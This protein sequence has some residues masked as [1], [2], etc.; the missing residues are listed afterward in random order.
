MPD[1]SALLPP[2]ATAFQGAATAP[3]EE[4]IEGRVDPDTYR[5]GPG[6]QFALR[7]SDLMDPRILRVSPAG[8]LLLPDAGSVP[9]A[10]LTLREVQAKVR[11]ALRPFIRGKGFALILDRPRRFRMPVLGE[12]ERRGVVT[13]QA[14]VRASEAIAAAGG[15]TYLGARRGIE[16]RRGTDTLRVDLVRYLNSGDLSANPLVFETDVLYVPA[17]GAKVGIAGAL[18]H[19]GDYDYMVGDRL[20]VL[21]AIAGGPLP[22]AALDAAELAR[23][24]AGDSTVNVPVKLAA[25]LATPGGP[26]DLPLEPGDR[27]F[28][29]WRAHWQE[30]DFVT[31]E[32]E[33][34]HPGGYP[35]LAGVT[36]LRDVL[37]RAGGYTSLADTAAVSV[38]RLDRFADQDTAFARLAKE[39]GDLLLSADKQYAVARSKER[40]AVSAPVGAL[41]ARGDSTGNILLMNGDRIV[42]PK[43]FPMVSVQGAV[44]A[45]GYVPYQPGLKVEE[46][47]KAAGGYGG[48]ADKGNTRVTLAAT[49]RQVFGKDAGTLQAGDAIWVPLSQGKNGWGIARDVITTLGIA[50]TIALAI[51]GINN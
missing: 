44:R 20:S 31:T 14:P 24:D 48:R 3:G 10:G 29:P 15:V 50:A 46:Y 37:E 32:G 19:P 9:V 23:L 47:V 41:L 33:V 49:G 11:E 22:P 21:V 8:E 42:V 30:I 51:Q 25:A 4:P 18:P 5:V 45:P 12:V 13:L 38:Y 28:I 35:I 16:V 39:S 6:D 27:L 36:R 34:E 43:R 17:A 1:P 7:Y 26:D 40:N 2:G